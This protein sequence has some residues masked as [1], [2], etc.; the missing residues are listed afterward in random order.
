MLPASLTTACSLDVL[1]KWLLSRYPSTSALLEE[2]EKDIL[3]EL[4]SYVGEAFRQNIGGIF[5][6]DL[7]DESN[8]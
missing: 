3:D 1:E 6:I 5:N 4:A 2:S 8:V 7:E